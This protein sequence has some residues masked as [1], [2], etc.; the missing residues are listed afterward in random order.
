MLKTA[1]PEE[2]KMLESPHHEEVR[3]ATLRATRLQLEDQTAKPRLKISGCKRMFH[4]THCKPD[5]LKA[6]ASL[7]NSFPPGVN[8]LEDE[9]ELDR[10]FDPWAAG[11]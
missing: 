4:C 9:D 10:E 5:A 1:V 7:S 8:E 3:K 6:R 2:V 11:K